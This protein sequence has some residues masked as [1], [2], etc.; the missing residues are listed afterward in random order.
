MKYTLFIDES[1]DFESPRGEWLIS[2]ALFQGELNDVNHTLSTKLKNIPEELGVKSIKDFHLTEFRRDFG[3]PTALKKAELL[4]TKVSKLGLGFKLFSVINYAKHSLSEREKTYRAMLGDMIALVDSVVDD[5][6]ELETLDIVVATRTIEGELQTTID[7]LRKEVINTLPQSLEYDLVSLGLTNLIGKNLRLSQEYANNSW[8][9]VCADFIANI[10]YHRKKTTEK[11]L[12]TILEREGC[13][14]AFEAFGNHA[15][16]RARIAERN[17][18]YVLAAYR[19][20]VISKTDDSS[21]ENLIGLI[22]KIYQRSGSTGA[23]TNLEA[24]IEKIWRYF[25]KKH[26]YD[27]CLTAFRLLETIVTQSDYE[28]FRFKPEYI[29][30]KIRNLMLLLMNHQGETVNALE[31]IE[32]QQIALKVLINNPE[33]LS[34]ILD[35]NLIELEFY[36]NSLEFDKACH[37]AEKYLNLI[38]N[39]QEVWALFNEEAG[40]KGFKQANFWIKSQMAALRIYSLSPDYC[41]CDLES[42]FA[43]LFSMD[44]GSFDQSRLK[45]YYLLYLLKSQ[46]ATKAYSLLNADYHSITQSNS[47][48]LFWILN[49]INA[50]LL[51]GITISEN[52]TKAIT[53]RLQDEKLL[54]KAHPNDMVWREAALYFWLVGDKS[55]ALKFIKRAKTLFSLSNSPIS[56]LLSDMTALYEAVMQEKFF[57]LS[58][59]LCYISI[60]SNQLHNKQEQLSLIQ[61]VRNLS[62]Y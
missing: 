33:N 19:W 49:V 51:K 22:N 5:G 61:H 56:N 23:K 48:D 7:D 24:L 6:D 35:F 38:N 47:F 44:L 53:I 52:N 60:N 36:V 15:Q 37:K 46:E 45:N 10:N 3:H 13:F 27:D 2:G 40:D 8:G 11:E 34:V 32:Q 55:I 29:M 50:V 21:K 14:L 59:K 26:N 9:L 39:Y 31:I 62:P 25:T 12:L 30:F 18:D 4:I 42:S 1:G 54:N 57:N 17:H 28:I 43:D 41:E 58:Q 16:R 20:I